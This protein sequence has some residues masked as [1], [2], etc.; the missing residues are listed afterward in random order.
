MEGGKEGERFRDL[1]QKNLSAN[2]N[3]EITKPIIE[4]AKKNKVLLLYP[5]PELG[6]DMKKKFLDETSKNLLK[7]KDEFNEDFPIISTSFDVFKDRNK[8]SFK[9]LDSVLHKNIIR[10]YPHKFFCDKQI[11]NRCVANDKKN[12][13]YID[14][15]HLS[16]YASGEIVK[17]IMKKI[18]DHQIKQ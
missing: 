6:W 16:D 3:D 14:T 2:F 15:D 8:Q 10:I 4:L 1:K 5:I 17:M 9:V 13:Y 12:L 7:I 18:Q 11:K